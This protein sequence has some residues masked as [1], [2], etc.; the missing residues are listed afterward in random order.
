[1]SCASKTTCA[2]WGSTASTVWSPSAA[3]LVVFDNIALTSAE[4]NALIAEIP[5]ISGGTF[6]SGNA[7]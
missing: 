2:S 1:M 7:P 4:I 6:I 3:A 5:T